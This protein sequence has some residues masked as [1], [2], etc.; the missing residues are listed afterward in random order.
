MAIFN[1]FNQFT[2]DLHH[3]VH[4]F[5]NTASAVPTIALCAAA[6]APVATNSVLANLTEIAYT[7]LST[8][9]VTITS[10]AQTSGTYK[11]VLADLI[12]SASGGAVATFRYVVL[13]ADAPTSPAD[14]LIGW[15]DFGSDVTLLDTQSLTVDFD[16]VGGVF[17]DAFA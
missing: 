13:Y 11:L 15:Y 1:P 14:P 6:N 5:T 10:S 9:A 8:R 2:E 12:L 16:G 4:N 7:N 3:G 17:T